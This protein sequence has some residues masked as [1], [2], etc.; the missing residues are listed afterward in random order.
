MQPFTVLDLYSGPGGLSKGIMGAKFKGL[1]FQ[2]ITATDYD[3]DTGETYKANHPNVD[4]ILGDISLEKTKKEILNSIKK[5]TGSTKIDV[6]IGG[7]PCRGFSQANT[8]TRHKSNPLNNLPFEFI[9]MVKRTKPFAFIMENVPGMLS[10][11]KGKVLANIIES[12][13]K[14]GYENTTYWLL[15]AADYGVPQFRK[16]TFIIG[17]KNNTVPLIPPNPTHGND[18]SLLP[19]IAL[20]KVLSDLPAIPIGKS[21][22]KLRYYK[23]HPKNEFQIKLRKK[24][25]IIKNHQATVSTDLILKRFKTI[26]QGGNWQNI[27]KHLIQINGKY[28]SLK[29]TQ[30]MIYR[31]L[32][33]SAPAVTITNFRKAMLIHPTQNRLLSVREAARIQTFPDNYKFKGPLHSMQQQ[34]SDAVPL[35]LSTAVGNSMLKHMT[36]SLN[37]V[38]IKNR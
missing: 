35:Q 1:T 2:V 16:R 23:D 30:S 18:P 10:L 22:P 25:K 33:L 11:N 24:L 19:Y 29:N 26:P 32:S 34:V 6:V 4:F 15:D 3:Y 31:R 8:V 17:S 36:K 5:S 28:K 27:P 21:E 14:L 37:F 12:F 20:S 9:D 7:P 38:K 13:Q